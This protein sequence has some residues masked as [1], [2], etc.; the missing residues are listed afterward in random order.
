MPSAAITGATGFLGRNLIELL[1]ARGWQL[2]ALVRDPQRAAGLLPQG[3][4]CLQADLLD[5]DALAAA[6]AE[7][8]DVLFHTAAD[9][10]TWSREAPRQWRVNRDGTGNLLAA[11]RECGIGRLVHV[12]TIAVYGRHRGTITEDSPRRGWG[13][14]LAYAES[15][16]AAEDAVQAA[17]A[18]GQDV[19]IVN[20]THVVGRYDTRNWARLICMVA[21]GSLPAVP[22]GGGCFAH[23]A[24]V[25]AA[26]VRAVES[27]PAGARYILGGPY[28][29][30]RQFV[31]LAARQLGVRVRAPAVPAFA[32]RA[33]ARAGAA[34]GAL[35]GRRPPV[36]PEEAAFA[37]D[38]MHAS[39]R[40]AETELGYTTPP[41]DAMIAESTEWL[42]RN[43][44]LHRR[45]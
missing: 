37:C 25:A 38:R 27:A 8:V 4:R 13:V 24:S 11:A 12:S 34:A 5:R 15:K 41:L 40:R 9:T 33:A 18:A 28:A 20:P 31:E 10:G 45:G 36:T 19:V 30:F 14:D 16:A 21:D 6:L 1:A 43:G 23:G 39:S 22:P 44:H 35:T 7:G 42:E 29:S 32:L 17:G 26:M 3:V 2:R